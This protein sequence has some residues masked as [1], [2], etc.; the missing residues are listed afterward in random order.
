MYL[1]DLVKPSLLLPWDWLSF[2]KGLLRLASLFSPASEPNARLSVFFL[3][4]G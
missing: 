4:F 2:L 1:T 3:V